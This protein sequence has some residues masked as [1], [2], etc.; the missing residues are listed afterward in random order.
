MI[1]T[2]WKVGLRSIETGVNG[3][4][5]MIWAS[6]AFGGLSA[7]AWMAAVLITPAVV[8]ATWDGPPKHVRKR[9]RTGAIFNATGA[10]FASLAMGCQ[11]WATWI[12]MP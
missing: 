5:M 2:Q 8:P 3:E 11:A 9:L 10:F 1:L 6:V 4:A 7:I 12:A